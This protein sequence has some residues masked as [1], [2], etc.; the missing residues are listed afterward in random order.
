M[1]E[2]SAC[3]HPG[4][5]KIMAC[6]GSL[7]PYDQKEPLTWPARGDGNGKQE[8]VKMGGTAQIGHKLRSP[9]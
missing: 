7:Y 8:P 2:Q 4:M 1:P 3:D 5:D 6:A 9:A